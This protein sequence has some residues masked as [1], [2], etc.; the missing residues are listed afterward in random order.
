MWNPFKNKNKNKTSII[1]ESLYDYYQTYGFPLSTAEL[2]P[3]GQYGVPANVIE[4]YP[5]KATTLRTVI[6]FDIVRTACRVVYERNANIKGLL[7]NLANFII[8]EG[9]TIKLY[10][11]EGENTRLVKEVEKYLDDIIQHNDLQLSYWQSWVDAQVDGEIFPR[12]F[13][14]PDGLTKIRFVM[15]DQIRPPMASDWEGE[16]SFGIKKPI[17]DSGGNP[18]LFNI[19]Y[20]RYNQNWDKLRAPQEEQVSPDTMWQLKLNTRHNTKRGI[21]SLAAC[22]DEA[23]LSKTLRFI[24]LKSEQERK[25][26]AYFRETQTPHGIQNIEGKEHRHKP[27]FC[28]EGKIS[29][30]DVPKTLQVKD[31]PFA[32]LASSIGILQNALETIAANFNCPSFMV[33]GQADASSYSSAVVVESQ[34]HKSCARQQQI[35]INLWKK[36]FKSI[37]EV[38]VAQE[39]LSPKALDLTLELKGPSPF[40]RNMKEQNENYFLLV[41]NKIMSQHKWASL[42][43]LNLE[44]ERKVIEIE[45]PLPQMPE[46]L[47]GRSNMKTMSGQLQRD[48]GNNE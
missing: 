36:I 11:D 46:T 44:S 26:I 8:G 31:P 13:P 30:V 2:T 40:G 3:P 24:A 29:V 48:E 42:N 41:Q 20:Y 16:W 28:E 33:T 34:F 35:I 23:Q 5:S 47:T 22:L 9:L 45:P 21:S 32:E 37:L 7:H 17:Y 18:E 39:V 25:Q 43:D 19:Y 4:Y 6:D 15:P 12:L 14:S 1:K 10:S 38:A 27:P